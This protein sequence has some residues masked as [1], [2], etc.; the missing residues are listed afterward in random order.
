L[1]ATR[2]TIAPSA[3]GNKIVKNKTPRGGREGGRESRSAARETGRAGTLTCGGGGAGWSGGSDPIRRREEAGMM[4]LCWNARLRSDP[5][6]AHAVLGLAPAHLYPRR[7]RVGWLGDSDRPG[8]AERLVAWGRCAV[9]P[10]PGSRVV[11]AR[12]RSPTAAVGPSAL[13]VLVRFTHSRVG[14]TARTWPC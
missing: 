9:G 5:A 4:I 14:T 8:R 3:P 1:E 12:P 13:V 11:P 10:S 7:R 6:A 2:R